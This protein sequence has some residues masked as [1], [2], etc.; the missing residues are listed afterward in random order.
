[1]YLDLDRANDLWKIHKSESGTHLGSIMNYELAIGSRVLSRKN[2]QVHQWS[3]IEIGV[4]RHAYCPVTTTILVRMQLGAVQLKENSVF[5]K[6]FTEYY[7]DQSLR[8][9]SFK[10]WYYCCFYWNKRMLKTDYS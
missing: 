6:L 9:R 1:M 8:N 5:W 10:T 2:A 7:G 3:L 4:E